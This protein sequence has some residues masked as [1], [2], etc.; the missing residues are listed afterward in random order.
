MFPSFLTAKAVYKK[1][2]NLISTFN[3][4]KQFRNKKQ[5]K[6]FKK[7]NTETARQ[8]TQ[9]MLKKITKKRGK[10][11]PP[12]DELPADGADSF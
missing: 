2:F 11:S 7:P 12:S 9:E 6:Y 10:L 1:I 8:K 5:K 4:Q 3:M